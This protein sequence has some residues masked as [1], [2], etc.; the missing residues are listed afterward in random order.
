MSYHVLNNLA[1]ESDYPFVARKLAAA[2]AI[3]KLTG[4]KYDKLAYVALGSSCMTR[5][6]ILAAG[7]QPPEL[8]E[9][10]SDNT[11]YIK[12]LK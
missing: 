4:E 11:L 6:Q 8:G 5:E 3:E 2:K 12:Y 10:V 1:G 7:G 9:Q